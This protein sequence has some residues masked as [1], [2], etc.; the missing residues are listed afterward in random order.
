MTWKNLTPFEREREHPGDP[1][2]D[3]S[4]YYIYIQY[5]DAEWQAV[6]DTVLFLRC[7]TDSHICIWRA[8]NLS[9]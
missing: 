1:G 5:T 9:H 8:F 7:F 3:N 4:N 2:S 6:M